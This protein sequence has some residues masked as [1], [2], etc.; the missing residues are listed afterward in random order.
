MAR[1]GPLAIFLASTFASGE[2]FAEPA[3]LSLEDA[4]APLPVEVAAVPWAE[5]DA[6]WALVRGTA[7][8]LRVTTDGGK[9]WEQIVLERGSQKP[10]GALGSAPPMFLGPRAGL[11]AAGERTW[12]TTNGGRAWKDAFG[13]YLAA[14][15]ADGLLWVA[16]SAAPDR[17]QSRISEDSGRTWLDCGARMDN[18]A[19]LPSLA[20]MTGGGGGWMLSA[21]S[22]PAVWTTMDGGC[23]WIRAGDAPTGA[24]RGIW[25]LDARSAWLVGG[26]GELVATTDGGLTWSTVAAPATAFVFFSTPTEGWVIGVDGRLHRSGDGGVTWSPLDRATAQRALD[27]PKLARWPAGR[28]LSLALAGGAPYPN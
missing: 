2:A 17:W 12:V 8:W 27:D 11:V 4:V 18:A 5:G 21:G 13:A 9:S 16:V 3:S 19:G 22:A 6:A 24:W 15:A 28:L 7:I 1:T 14:G 20:W 10:L 26:R 23:N 25:A